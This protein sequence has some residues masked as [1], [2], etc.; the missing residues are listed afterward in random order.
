M[1]FQ[2]CELIKSEV[3]ECQLIRPTKQFTRIELRPRTWCG[4]HRATGCPFEPRIWR[5]CTCSW[6]VSCEQSF[7]RASWTTQH[8]QSAPETS[9]NWQIDIFSFE[10]SYSQLLTSVIYETAKKMAAKATKLKRKKETVLSGSN[11]TIIR[12]LLKTSR[13]L[14]VSHR[15]QAVKMTK[16]K[17]NGML[18]VIGRLYGGPL[19]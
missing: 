9:Y 2:E 18:S 7:C 14:M 16:E 12:T 4:L 8:R 6:A 11:G 13:G 19:E 1:N 15:L 5:S 17:T 10:L 3:T